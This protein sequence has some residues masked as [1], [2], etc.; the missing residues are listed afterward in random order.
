MKQHPEVDARYPTVTAMVESH[1][2]IIFDELPPMV[3]YEV[4][5]ATSRD[6]VLVDHC[7]LALD[8]ID[9]IIRQE[10]GGATIYVQGDSSLSGIISV[11]AT[12]VFVPDAMYR[13]LV[14]L[15]YTQTIYRFTTAAKFGSF[16]MSEKQLRIN[17]WGKELCRTKLRAEYVDIHTK[18]FSATHE[19]ILN[20]RGHYE[21]LVQLL[22][23][24]VSAS[25]AKQVARLNSCLRLRLVS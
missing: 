8:A 16:D 3:K 14:E 23:G 25:V 15:M 24:N 20:E 21:D 19:I 18:L 13:A 12:C 1:D 6:P 10:F 22:T 9:E 2:V 5:R 7:L 17:A 11:A 4:I